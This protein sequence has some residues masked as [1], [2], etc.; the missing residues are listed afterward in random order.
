MRRRRY[1]TRDELTA[2]VSAERDLPIPQIEQI[3][4]ALAHMGVNVD[5]LVKIEVDEPLP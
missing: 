5:Q 4:D 1:M 2:E 3:L